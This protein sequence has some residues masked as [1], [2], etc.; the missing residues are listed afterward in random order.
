VFGGSRIKVGIN[1]KNIK[2]IMD[3]NNKKNFGFEL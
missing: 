1:D 3:K 2:N